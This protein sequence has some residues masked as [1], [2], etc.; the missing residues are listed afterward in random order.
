M[1]GPSSPGQFRYVVSHGA[2]GCLAG[3][4]GLYTA[5]DG[6]MAFYVFDGST[7]T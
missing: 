2:Q 1:R 7:S 3:S 5:Q 4:Y 6:G